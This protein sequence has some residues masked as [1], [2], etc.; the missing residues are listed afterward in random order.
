MLLI[1]NCAVA[2]MVRMAVE[3]AALI[4]MAVFVALVKKVTDCFVK[5][6]V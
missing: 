4:R 3:L 6:Y 5:L 1:E 2:P